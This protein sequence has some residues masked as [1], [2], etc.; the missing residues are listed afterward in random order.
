MYNG[1]GTTQTPKINAPPTG[2]WTTG[3]YDCCDDTGNCCLTWCCPRF[4]FGRNV[5]IIDQGR[6][7][8]TIARLIFFALGCFGLASLY[9]CGFRSKLRA[10]YNLP[11]EPCSDCCVHYCCLLCAICQEYRELKN[12]GLDPSQGW[13]ANEERLRRANLVPPHVAPA[14]TR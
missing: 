5:D 12:R 2:K 9:T 4:T 13:R 14:M 10:I 8:P 1:E 6:T 7:S 11:E 3:L